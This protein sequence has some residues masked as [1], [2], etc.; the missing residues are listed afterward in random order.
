MCARYSSRLESIAC[1][2]TNRVGKSQ[3]AFTEDF[4]IEYFTEGS[5][6]LIEDWSSLNFEWEL[7]AMLGLRESS[8]PFPC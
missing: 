1:L 8:R 7:G 3:Q 6:V 5:R 2:S 4:L